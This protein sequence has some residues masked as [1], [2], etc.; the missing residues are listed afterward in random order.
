MPYPQPGVE[1]L[2]QRTLRRIATGEHQRLVVDAFVDHAGLRPA[3][4]VPAHA[5][6]ENVRITP[7]FDVKERPHGRPNHRFDREQIDRE[8]VC[9]V[10]RDRVLGIHLRWQHRGAGQFDADC[11]EIEPLLIHSAE[12]SHLDV[13]VGPAQSA[14]GHDMSTSIVTA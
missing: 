13:D 14:K 10:R 3:S 9:V 7:A 12:K 4:E 5:V 1:G 2:D 8:S 6:V 11:A